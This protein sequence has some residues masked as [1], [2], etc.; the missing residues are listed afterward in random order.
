MIR[1]NRWLTTT[2]RWV[3]AF[4]VELDETSIGVFNTCEGLGL[5]VVHRAARRGRQQHNGLAAAD[6]D[7]VQ[8][9]Q[10]EPADRQ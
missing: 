6:P 1:R 4:A 5:E 7:E 9:H 3:C 10:A 2:R 8:Q